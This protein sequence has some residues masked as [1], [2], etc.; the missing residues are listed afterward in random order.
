MINTCIIC[1]KEFSSA[2]VAALSP[3]CKATPS[4]CVVCG[5]EFPRKTFP[6]TQKTCSAK[7]R[8][9]YRKG[10]G[11]AK[12]GAAKMKQTK[13]DR[14]GTLDPTEVTVAKSGELDKRVCPF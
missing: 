13:L 3:E 4:V 2:H 10:S 5:K 8:G 6:Y 7:C 9:I 11:I 14:Y 12:Q 1:N